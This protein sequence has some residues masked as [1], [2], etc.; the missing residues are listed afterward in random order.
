MDI[1]R[2]AKVGDKIET[3][4][5]QPTP[6]TISLTLCTPEACAGAN[7]LLADPKSGWSLSKSMLKET[8]VC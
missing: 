3:T 1:E 4:V 5:R 6:G 2:F 8:Q 7:R